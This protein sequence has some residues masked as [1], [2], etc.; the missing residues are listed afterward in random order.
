MWAAVVLVMLGSAPAAALRS[1]KTRI[2]ISNS[3]QK[4]SMMSGPDHDWAK[5]PANTAKGFT[6]SVYSA[7]QL[8]AAVVKDFLTHA[9]ASIR[10]AGAFYCAVPGGSVL[11]MLGGLKEH[12]NDVDFSKIHMFYA[13][14]KCVPDN[15]G[16]ATH[17]KAK[18]LFLDACPI[19]AY[20]IPE[21]SGAKGHD[22][23]AHEYAKVMKSVLPQTNGL[24]I[25]D[26]MLLG[27]G[28]DGHIGSLYPDRPEVFMTAK[29]P[30]VL[31]VDKKQPSSI[32][33]SLPVMNG[34]SEV[35]VVLAGGDKAEAV[36]SG[37]SRSKA[38]SA[39]PAC[40]IAKAQWMIDGPAA[41]LLE[42]KALVTKE[43][44]VQV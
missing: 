2:T 12:K 33:L 3:N 17:F 10:R 44:Y 24:P 11:K 40:G 28:K 35:R 38:A 8:G 37:V 42:G 21:S 15:D 29:E 9:E 1:T 22:T 32:T 26:Y 41:A 27:M 13:N 18:G 4:L 20:A 23:D 34:A 5:H 36:L 39:F 25:F 16:S 6:V 7:E 43:N 19:N 30:W 14:H 31:T